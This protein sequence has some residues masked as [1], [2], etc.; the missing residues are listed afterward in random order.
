MELI[1][2]GYDQYLDFIE[3]QVRERITMTHTK[4]QPGLH[5]HSWDPEHDLLKKYMVQKSLGEG[6][7][8]LGVASFSDYGDAYDY[9]H[10]AE[11]NEYG[12]V[13]RYTGTYRVWDQFSNESWKFE[14]FN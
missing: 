11:A 5:A 13:E 2:Q 3:A 6:R 1:E 4:E 12:Y 10:A 8:W 14:E 7:G 9:I